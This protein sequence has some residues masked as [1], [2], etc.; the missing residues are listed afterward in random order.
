[1]L[2]SGLR[3]AEAPGNIYYHIYVRAT[4]LELAVLQVVQICNQQVTLILGG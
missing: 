3:C 4:P 1:M 2:V